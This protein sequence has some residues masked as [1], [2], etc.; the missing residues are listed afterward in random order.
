MN[1][2]DKDFQY[3]SNLFVATA[4][5]QYEKRAWKPTWIIYTE[6]KK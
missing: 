5:D 4:A 3:S 2:P 1:K 6:Q